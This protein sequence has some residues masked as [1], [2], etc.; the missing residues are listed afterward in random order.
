MEKNIMSDM[1]DQNKKP[2]SFGEYRNPETDEPLTERDFMPVRQSREGRSGLLGGLMYFVFVIS[3]SVILAC[4]AW[5]AATDVLALNADTEHVATVILP[6][7]A[8]TYEDYTVTQDD[9][10]TDT[11]TR[12]TADIDY[13]ADALNKAGIVEYKWLFKFYCNFSHA[14]TKLDPGT[15]ELKDVY[16]Y[17]ALVKKMQSG[18]SAMV[19]IN[20]TFPE[21]YTM[22]Q[23]FKKLDENGVCD[24]NELMDAAANSTFTYSFLADIEKGDPSRLEGFLFPDTYE[25]FE[26]MPAASA[27][28]RMLEGFYYKLTAEMLDW[29]EES[30]LTMRQIVT[31]ASMIE[32]EASGAEGERA[33]IAS[34]IYNRLN[35]GWPLQVDATSLYEHP[36]HVGAPTAEMLAEDSPYNTRINTGLTPTP[37]CNPGIES[38]K[39]ALRPADTDYKFYALNTATGAHEFFSSASAFENFVATQNYG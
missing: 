25:F 2:R 29:L 5:M 26:G 30:G 20:I 35:A 19:R 23:M 24:Y 12:H 16:D 15:Y 6:K 8:F 18:S 11:K 13:V 9:G 4:L 21:G 3:V 1:N 33:K 34:V 36:D 32:K 39:A 37:I 14:E 22:R 17:R 27:I 28:N 38:I 31:I 7:S 10:T